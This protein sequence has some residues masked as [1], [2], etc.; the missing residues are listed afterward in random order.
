MT[1]RFK[2][3]RNVRLIHETSFVASRIADNLIGHVENSLMLG[4]A[5]D[6]MT[7]EETDKLRNAFIDLIEEELKNVSRS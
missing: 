5:Y 6:C 4:A 2:E 7:E 1:A 3:L